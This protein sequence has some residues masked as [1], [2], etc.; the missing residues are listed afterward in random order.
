MKNIFTLLILITLTS[1]S[2][3]KINESDVNLGYIT[4]LQTI[5]IEGCKYLFGDWH[6]ATVLTH[7]GN[8]N[9]K[10]HKLKSEKNEN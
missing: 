2:Q 10:I 4:P 3:D 1:C 9:N 5:E 7:K 6:N 8:C